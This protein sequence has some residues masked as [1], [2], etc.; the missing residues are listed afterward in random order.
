MGPFECVPY[1]SGLSW[2]PAQQPDC[3]QNGYGAAWP[4]HLCLHSNGAAG[5]SWSWWLWFR[6]GAF[7]EGPLLLLEAF[8]SETSWPQRCS[9]SSFFPLLLS[10]Y[11]GMLTIYGRMTM[12]FFPLWLLLMF[13]EPTL[14]FLG[15]P[16]V[17][18]F[19]EAG[20][21]GP[22]SV[23]LLLLG[24]QISALAPSPWFSAVQKS[25]T[26]LYLRLLVQQ[27][28]TPVPFNSSLTCFTDRHQLPTAITS[29]KSQLRDWVQPIQTH[30][31]LRAQ[32]LLQLLE[33]RFTYAH[34]ASSNSTWE[35]GSVKPWFIQGARTEQ[36]DLELTVFGASRCLIKECREAG[37]V[38]KQGGSTVGNVVVQT[39]PLTRNE[40][41]LCGRRL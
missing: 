31:Y 22:M 10:N 40:H 34:N 25:S 36:K 24:P 18:L 28:P 4:S 8:G 1:C 21:C 2:A 19:W 38:D 33:R 23:W 41:C 17:V 6:T 11:T 12:A 7:H 9:W 20:Q 14:A 37:C 16:V 30:A 5:C 39:N 26:Y 27:A 3:T 35:M 32:R 15:G 29:P 13:P